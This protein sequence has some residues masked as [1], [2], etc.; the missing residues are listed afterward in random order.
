MHTSPIIST[1]TIVLLQCL[2]LSQLP[3]KYCAC[4]GFTVGIGSSIAA[5]ANS[6]RYSTQI[7]GHGSSIEK[8]KKDHDDKENGSDMSIH[9]FDNVFSPYACE[10]L[11]YLSRD[12]STRGNDGSSVFV[13]PPHNHRPLTPIEHAIDSFLSSLGDSTQKVEYWSRDEYM[14]IDVHADIDEEQLEDDNELRCPQMAHVLYL[15]VKNDLRGPTCIFP[16]KRMGWNSFSGNT[17][18]DEGENTDET[19]V[20]LVTVPAVLGRVLRFPGNAMHSVPRPA[21]RWLLS[22]DEE[23]CLREEEMND[24]D[25]ELDDCYEDEDEDEDEEVERAVLLFNTWADNEPAPKGVNGDYISGSLPEGIEL[26]EEDSLAFFQSEEARQLLEWEE[27]YG[28]SAENIRCNPM[29]QWKSINVKDTGCYDKTYNEAAKEILRIGLMGKQ[30][31]RL[32]DNKFVNL[33]GRS[34]IVK[35]ALC[36]ENTPNLI[37]LLGCDII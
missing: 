23:R 30:N 37:R 31:R 26:S 36:E 20:D 25:R 19:N 24:G 15:E 13:R 22:K 32:H 29:H 5:R 17:N 28:A 3:G 33:S 6:N 7:Y 16:T 4:T 35:K 2:T 10:E 8:Q 11:M 34:D 9:V 1:I 12:H 27:D 18:C 21:H 14:N